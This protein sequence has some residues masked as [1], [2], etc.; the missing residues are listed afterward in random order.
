MD[1]LYLTEEEIQEFKRLVKKHKGIDL[2][3]DEALDQGTRL[4]MIHETYIKFKLNQDFNTQ[5]SN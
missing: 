5:C 1:G 4:V 2:T 3:D